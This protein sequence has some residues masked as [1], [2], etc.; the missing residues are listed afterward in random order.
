MVFSE[1]KIPRILQKLLPKKKGGKFILQQIEYW[2]RL[3]KNKNKPE[4]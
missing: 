2:V 3:A 4:K 1:L